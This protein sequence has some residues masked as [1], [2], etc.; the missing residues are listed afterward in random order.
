MT[1]RLG[2]QQPGGR[3]P[4]LTWVHAPVEEAELAPPYAL[5]TAGES[6]HWLAWDVVFGRFADVLTPGGVLAIIDRDW[7]LV[8]AVGERLFSIIGRYS[9]NRAFRPYDLPAELTSRGLF[10]QQ[11][12]CRMTPSHGT[13]LSLTTSS[14]VTL[15]TAS[16]ESGWGAKPPLRTMQRPRSVARP[17]P[18][19]RARTPRGSALPGGRLGDHLGPAA[20]IG[21]RRV[22]SK[23][24]GVHHTMNPSCADVPNGRTLKRWTIS[25][26][27]SGRPRNPSRPMRT[28]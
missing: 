17:L 22:L 15:R 8:A 6:L 11:G 18:G 1:S 26:R 3:A 13:R 25:N 21:G 14:A 28:G 10:E 7:D 20:T 2:R 16:R 4:N 5:I 23:P 24:H 9:T 27:T 19:G 12:R